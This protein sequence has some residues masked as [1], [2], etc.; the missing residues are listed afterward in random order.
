[1]ITTELLIIFILLLLNAF[2]AM[3]EM[4]IVSASKPLLRQKAKQGNKRAALALHLKED[5]GR[6][7]S[8]VQV[9]ITL[10]GT[11]AG[12]YGG[13]EIADKIAPK[14]DEIAFIAPQGELVAVILVVAIITYLSVVIGELIPKQFALSKPEILAM[15]AARPMYFLSI[16]CTPVVAALEGSANIF[17]RIFGIRREAEKV[18]E[19][20]IRAM[21][22]EGV[23]SGAIEKSEHDMLTRIIRL[24]DRNVESIMTHRVDIT[25]IDINDSITAIREKVHKAG[26]S[27]Y[28]VVDGDITKVIGVV[29]AKELLD[30][31]LTY[32]DD[33]HILDHLKEA[34]FIPEGTKCLSVLE[35]FKTS[36][37]HIAIVVNEYGVAEG[38][39]T[40][41]DVLEAIVGLM[42]SNYGRDE[43]PLITERE[44][45]SWLV[46]GATPIDE[47]HLSIGLEDISANASYET[48]AGFVLHTMGRTPEAGEFIERYGHR[49]EIV[50]LDARRIDKILITR[51]PEYIAG[52]GNTYD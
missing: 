3:S 33:L 43:E 12:A 25:F 36:S 18:T 13:A 41:S 10:V 5:S 52:A 27:R 31:A 24:G 1:M 29:Q 38:I 30:A 35:L 42:P 2:F 11:L 26:H 37:A 6:F 17:F 14:F 47:I 4:A 39:V 51:I 9:G 50:D 34:P 21:L 19:T 48:I 32:S 40:T 20:E 22:T 8:T 44:D 23:A 28:P 15:W 45:G 7:L 46:D 49:F 16:A